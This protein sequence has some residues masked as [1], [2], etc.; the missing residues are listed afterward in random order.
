MRIVTFNVQNLR[1]RHPAG[2]ARLDGARDSDAPQDST[3]EA[4]ALDLADRRLTSAI[5]ARTDAD[6]ICLQEVF[7]RATLDFFHDHL[8]RHAGAR[9]YPHRICLPGNDGGGRDLAV[10]SRHPLRDVLS[11]S[12]L[13]PAA[14]GLTPPPGVRGD[15][16][17]F[18][19][20]CLFFR[21]GDLNLFHCHFKAPR[22]DPESAWRIRRMEALAVRK[23]VEAR[24]RNNRDALWLLLGDLN[25][26]EEQATGESAIAPLL[27]PLSVDLLT[28][29]PKSE[30]WTFYDAQD[31]QYA[32]PDGLLASPT[33]AARW[34]D[35]VPKAVR[36]GLDRNAIRAGE[37]R[38]ADTGLHRPHASDHT[39]LVL[40]LDGL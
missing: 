14:L 32:C 37:E 25:E 8:M 28:R 17:I 13:T 3:S 36:T 39:A 23:L 21:V 5:L 27:P 16:P 12:S 33:L 19:R 31:E 22:P 2:R 35:A 30:R 6:L 24:F 34:P 29:M 15:V 4:G 38:L 40:D 20:D 18:R 11:H 26:T 10:M 7:D 1:L 9:A